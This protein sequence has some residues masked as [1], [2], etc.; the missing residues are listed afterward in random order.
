MAKKGNSNILFLIFGLLAVFILGI[1]VGQAS[2]EC[3]Y[4]PPEDVDFSLMWEVWHKLEDTYVNPGSINSQ[5]LVYGAIKGMV[6]A[7]EDP[8]TMFFDPEETKIFLEDV[9][10]SFEGVGM[11]IGIRNGQLQV[12]SPV[13]GTPADRAG[14]RAGDKI[15]KV[16]DTLTLDITIEEAVT[17]IRGPKGTE[18]V[19]TI[20]RKGWDST[21]EFRIKRD[22][23]EIP[24]MEWELKEDN[25][26]YIKLYH[27]TDKSH[28]DFQNIAIDVLNSSAEKIILDLRNNPGGYLEMTVQIAGWFLDRGNVVLIED[29]G[30]KQ[31]Q[32]ERLAKGNSR[33]IGYPTVV[34]INQGSA[35]ASEIL[36]AALRDNRGIELIGETS[37]GKGSVQTLLSLKDDSSLKV[38][39]ANWLTPNGDLINEKGLEPDIKVELTEEDYEQERDP[40]LDKAL[41]IIRDLD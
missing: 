40:Q 25:I 14:L 27:F 3:P 31:E 11:E 10:G 13:K 29:Y 30:D 35:S 28:I 39:I 6:E 18:V 12:I 4:C 32:E 5:A 26:A 16:D 1:F 37:Y 21:Q 2:K 38:T 24:S 9:T 8:Y 7:V 17:L 33:L 34:L 41:E 15:I 19:L 36:A 22:V 20:L 23:I